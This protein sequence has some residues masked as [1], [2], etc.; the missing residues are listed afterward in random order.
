MHRLH[1]TRYVQYMCFVIASEELKICCR[2]YCNE[3]HNH[4]IFFTWC[5]QSCKFC[6]FHQVSPA[7]IAT[8][9]AL[10]VTFWL[11]RI[12]EM[13]CQIIY[14]IAELSHAPNPYVTWGK[15]HYSWV[16]L[17]L[18]ILANLQHTGELWLPVGH[19]T[20]FFPLI[21]QCTFSHHKPKKSYHIDAWTIHHLC[22]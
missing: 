1:E 13:S 17:L 15:I 19:V 4:S 8:T 5:R 7:R 20:T 9:R 2:N 3:N 22:Q 6:C 11:Q 16:L 12:A 21:T 10:S 14:T 18:G